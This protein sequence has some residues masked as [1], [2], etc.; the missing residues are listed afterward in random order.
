MAYKDPDRAR[1]YDRLRKRK[2]RAEKK[3]GKVR[4]SGST[5]EVTMERRRE[6]TVRS[7]SSALDGLEDFDKKL[8]EFGARA[9]DLASQGLDLIEPEKLTAIDVKRLAEVG[10]AMR[11][12]A[13]QSIEG[14]EGNATER[15]ILHERVLADPEALDHVHALLSMSARDDLERVFEQPNTGP[16][17]EPCSILG[18]SGLL[19]EG[20]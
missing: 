13:A 15:I 10:L 11:N 17:P 7:H 9:L 5:K 14:R 8:L 16:E 18:D 6:V 19:C 4:L 12:F 20:S 2:A 3:L 1:E